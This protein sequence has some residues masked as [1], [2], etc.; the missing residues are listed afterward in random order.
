M[1]SY[2]TSCSVSIS[3]SP[4]STTNQTSGAYATRMAGTIDWEISVDSLMSMDGT[5]IK[6][7]QL[8]ATYLD[9]RTVFVIKWKTATSGDR[10]FEADAIMT[11][12]SMDNPNQETSTMNCTFA[13]TGP[14]ALQIV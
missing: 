2:A 5:G 14:L 1:V 13:G 9:L 10:Y 12:M 8:W 11:G 7:Y 3:H 4:R 6:W